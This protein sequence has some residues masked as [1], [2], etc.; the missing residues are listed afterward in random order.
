MKTKRLWLAWLYMFALCAALGF[1]PEPYGL[2]KALLVIA[3]LGFFVPGGLLL[4]KGD[5]KT[6]KKLILISGLSLVLT[7]VLIILN[8]ASALMP[9][10]WGTIF[11]ILMGI[12]ATPMLCSQYWVLSLFGW[13]CL[14]AAAVFKLLEKR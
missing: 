6:V 10:V 5:R 2:V 9:E 13:A 8:F 12:I 14:L 3:A 11:Y 1:I 4:A 7:M